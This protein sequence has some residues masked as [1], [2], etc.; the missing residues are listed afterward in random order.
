MITCARAGSTSTAL[1]VLI[2]IEQSAKQEFRDFGLGISRK[3]EVRPSNCSLSLEASCELI[4]D[5][6]KPQTE[7]MANKVKPATRKPR[8]REYWQNG[9]PQD[10]FLTSSNLQVAAAVAVVS[11][12][13]STHPI[14]RSRPLSPPST[15]H[16]PRTRPMVPALH[17]APSAHP[18]SR[19]RPL[20]PPS[21]AHR[22]RTRYR[23]PARCPRP[24]PRTVRASD[25]ALPPLRC[26]RYR[27]PAPCPRPP[28]RTV[29]APDIALWPLVPVT[30]RSRPLSPPSTAHR[31]RTRYR[32]PAP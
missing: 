27:A 1:A 19:S 14:S 12:A 23:A 20:S 6:P 31:P 22:P 3:A 24:S 28:L 15:A 11:F 21:T 17:R 18:I 8:R 9:S 16:R 32:A 29:R 2:R 26:T 25:I 7:L 5:P 13:P 30:S 4:S 10:S